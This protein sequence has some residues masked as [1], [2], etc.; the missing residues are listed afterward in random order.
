MSNRM[1]VIDIADRL[2]IGKMAVYDM[3]ERG[4]VPGIRIGRRWLVTRQAYEQWERTCGLAQQNVA[5]DTKQLDVLISD[6]AQVV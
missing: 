1:S 5:I 4:I 6:R 2:A 3:L